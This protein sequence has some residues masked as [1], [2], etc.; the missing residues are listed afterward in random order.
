[1][2][3]RILILDDN[4]ALGALFQQAFMRRGFEVYVASTG[5]DALRIVANHPIDAAITD[6]ELPEFSGLEFCRSLT[7]QYSHLRRRIP[8]WLMSGLDLPELETQAI[9]AGA[10]GLLRKPFN[11]DAAGDEIAETLQEYA[12][13]L[14]TGPNAPAACETT[15]E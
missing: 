15:L 1:M 9:A 6:F 4:D 3:I 10:C 11:L 12:S 8:V 13:H 14:A 7:R 2:P 5:A